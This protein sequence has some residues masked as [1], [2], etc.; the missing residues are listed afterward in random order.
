MCCGEET[1]KNESIQELLE[2]CL[3][4]E[5]WIY[6]VRDILGIDYGNPNVADLDNCLLVSESI[7]TPLS[8]ALSVLL[9]REVTARVKQIKDVPIGELSEQNI[10]EKIDEEPTIMDVARAARLLGLIPNHEDVDL[11]NVKNNI[12]LA[13][14]LSSL[15]KTP[16]ILENEELRKFK[17]LYSIVAG[18]ET[19]AKE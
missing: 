3:K 1:V 13:K 12:E 19:E 9:K 18:Y 7:I 6:A 8:G 11:I 17:N 14:Q 16:R 10:A 4:L 15:G 5:T 2:I